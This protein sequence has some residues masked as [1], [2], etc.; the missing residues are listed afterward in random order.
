MDRKERVTELNPG[1]FQ[2]R[3]LDGSS[4]SYVIRGAHLNV[5]ID[6][7]ADHNFPV[8]ERGLCEIGL[9]VRDIDLLINTHEHC[10]HIGANRYFQEHALVAAYRLAA[11]KMISGDYYVTMYKGND[12]NEIP[13]RVHLWLENMTRIDLGNY[14]LRVFHTPGHTSGCICIYEA[15]QGLLFSADTIFANGTLAY[16]AESGS[17]GDYIDSL[18]RLRCFGLSALY[19]GHGRISTTPVEDIDRAI[20][21]AK[22]LLQGKNEDRLEVFFQKD[23]DIESDRSGT[24]S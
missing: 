7:G 19:P 6:S 14:S 21:N 16:I 9:R 23:K 1:I 4:H 12:L 22:L 17:V 24:G 5:L 13:M 2:V 18:R 15:T 20:E 3:G 10:D 11:S 8:L